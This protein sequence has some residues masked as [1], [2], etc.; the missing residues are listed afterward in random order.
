MEIISA[1]LKS[2]GGAPTVFLGC[3]TDIS[4]FKSTYINLDFRYYWADDDL[5]NDFIGFETIDL[6]GYRL[7]TGVQWHF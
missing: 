7:T 4:I 5:S 3:G 2:S 6:G 1:T